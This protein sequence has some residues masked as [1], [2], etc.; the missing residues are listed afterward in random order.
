GGPS[1]T[2]A[3]R[4]RGGG[5]AL[6]GA[7][8]AAARAAGRR[9]LWLI[10]TNNNL[11]ALRFYQRRRR[12]APAE[13]RHPGRRPRRRSAAGRAR[14]GEAPVRNRYSATWFE[15]FLET[16]PPVQTEPRLPSL[17]RPLP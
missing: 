12:G 4:P 7:V 16:I 9:R 15:T 8:E 14:A 10:T 11:D 6:L 2:G 5:G 1:L 17:S 13:A 3:A